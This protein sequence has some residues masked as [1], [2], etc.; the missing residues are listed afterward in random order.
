MELKKFAA[1]AIAGVLTIS[2]TAPIVAQDMLM[3]DDAIAERKMLMKSNGKNLKAAFSASGDDAIAAAQT[4]VDNFTALADLWPEDSM[5]GD[6]KALPA[7]WSENENFL[8]AMNNATGAAEALLAA[9]Q[10]G[11]AGAFGAAAK[12][13][14]GTCGACHGKYQAK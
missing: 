5:D 13:M 7:V 4:L 2:S 11:D 14:G 6:T 9:A 8:V 10:A 1:L 12:A 3:G